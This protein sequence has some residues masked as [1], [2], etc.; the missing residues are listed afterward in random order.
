[1][2]QQK[3]PIV[4]GGDNDSLETT[5]TKVTSSGTT[6]S[7][8][9]NSLG[10]RSR[11]KVGGLVKRLNVYLLLFI[12]LILIAGFITLIAIQS[13]RNN[14]NQ[15]T[16]D[17]QELSADSLD[18]LAANN[19]QV[20]DAKQ[21][22]TI[23]SNA[24]FNGRVLI[25]DSLDVAGTIRVGGALSLPG[26]TVSGT[27]N[28]DQVQVAN[29]LAIAGNATIQGD[30]SA[31]GSLT[32]SGGA[33]F[34][35]PVS[36]PSLN[37][38]NLTLNND[39][40][41][42]RH[43]NTSGGIPGISSGAS[44]GAGGTVS[45]SGSDISGTVTINTGGGPGAGVLANISFS[46]AYG[47]TPHVVITPIGSGGASISYYVTRTA[48]GFSIATASPPPGASSFSFDYIVVN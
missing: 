16:L 14:D 15:A 36:T 38:E 28:F 48:S 30:L 9:N 34:G 43:I 17:G 46:R 13:A 4:T 19:T 41:L 29:N 26:I 1:M 25:R 45:L 18:E 3:D 7:G 2:E 32:V 6:P 31:Q 21:T 37:T 42:N 22:L 20:G 33:S 5:E 24:I 47:R 40:N 39:L 10:K 35:G 8:E 23:A 27:S 12:L 11:K 44:V